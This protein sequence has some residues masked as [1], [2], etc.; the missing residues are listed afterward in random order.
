M[1]WSLLRN[2]EK[3]RNETETS[4]IQPSGLEG[5]APRRP[6]SGPLDSQILFWPEETWKKDSWEAEQCSNNIKRQS[7]K[8]RHTLLQ[9][10]REI[11][12]NMR[13]LASSLR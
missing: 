10:F 2:P 12:G 9:R 4:G 5:V 7:A 3:G 13:G 6:P 1:A 8:R 11:H